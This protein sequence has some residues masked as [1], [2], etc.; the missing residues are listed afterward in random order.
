MSQA[1]DDVLLDWKEQRLGPSDATNALREVRFVIESARSASQIAEQAK[2]LLGLAVIAEPLFEAESG[3]DAFVLLTIPGVARPDRADLF[4]VAAALRKEIEATTVEP[5]LGTDYFQPEQAPPAAGAPEGVDWTFWCWADQG[6]TDRDWA[7]KST[8]V[9][10]AWAFSEAEGKPVG[11]DG[12][13]I[14]QPD[15]GVVVGHTELP[16]G[17]ADDPRA[18]N[19]VEGGKPIDPRNSG[20][21]PGH[22]TGTGSVVASPLEGAMRGAAPRAT[23]VPIR[24]I[25]TV[26]VVDQSNVARA[27]DHARRRGAHVITMSLGGVLS[28]ALHAAVRRAVEANVIVLAAA[29]NCVV[30]VVWPARYPEVIAL[31]GF[32]EARMPWRGSCRGPA[33]AFSAPAEF[34][35][36]ADGMHDATPPSRVSGGQGTSF[37]TALT[38]GVAAL[39]LAHHRRESLIASLPSGATLQEAFRRAARRSVSKPPEFDHSRY[40]AGV[41][42][43]LALLQLPLDSLWAQ[44]GP[45]SPGESIDASLRS[46]LE[47]AFGEEGPEAAAPA[48]DDPQHHAEL[49]CV[50]L[51]RVRANQTRRA[52][53]EALPPPLMSPS[54]RQVLARPID[55]SAEVLA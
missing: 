34:V 38:A 45:E 20:G 24:C 23:L 37:A 18:A 49:A 39:W 42:D 30:E 17:V 14:F 41:L 51:D 19:F 22:G 52:Q 9:P 5:D 36:R 47:A 31:G 3:L 15:T 26:A 2:A 50:A 1:I 8:R 27:I 10:E 28:R 48:L 40:G 46:L 55:Q 6:P 53:A 54:L 32:N 44:A 35:L 4:E 7:L 11:G 25:K 29:G 21:N 13:A 12:I 16:A 43:A 33:V